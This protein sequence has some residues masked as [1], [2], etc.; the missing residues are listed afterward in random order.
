[1]PLAEEADRIKTWI[2][3]ATNFYIRDQFEYLGF[4]CSMTKKDLTFHIEEVMRQAA[5]IALRERRRTDQTEA[6]E[7]I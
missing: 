7:G 1:M 5:G 6:E 4:P 2:E 3:E